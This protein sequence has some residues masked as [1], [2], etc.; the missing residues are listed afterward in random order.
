MKAKKAKDEVA[1]SSA[2]RAR[3][4]ILERLAHRTMAAGSFSGV[5]LPALAEHYLA[6]L[7][8]L[9]ELVDRPLAER[10]LASF[11]EL[12]RTKLDEGFAASP[13]AR[14][15]FSYRPLESN[16]KALSCNIEIVAPSLEEQ[17]DEWVKGLGA[18]DPFGKHPDARV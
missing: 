12:F 17:Y 6:K 5:C 4:A 11:R 14:F 1:R 15:V 13:Y 16:P 9:F 3:D 2:S 18:S 8:T 7:V 10:E